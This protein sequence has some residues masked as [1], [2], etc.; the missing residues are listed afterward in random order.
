MIFSDGSQARPDA[1]RIGWLT[2]STSPGANGGRDA[3]SAS[4]IRTTNSAVG[5]QSSSL[6]RPVGGHRDHG[7]PGV[8]R[9]HRRPDG[10][11]LGDPGPGVAAQVGARDDQV[12]RPA[13]GAHRGETREDGVRRGAA[14]GADAGIVGVLEV[15]VA[16][17]VGARAAAVPVRGHLDDVVP[18]TVSA[19]CTAR[20]PPASYPSSSV[21]RMRSGGA[22][23]GR[24]VGGGRRGPGAGAATAVT[25]RPQAAAPCSRTRSGL[26]RRRPRRRSPRGPRAWV[27]SCHVSG[28]GELSTARGIGGRAGVG[29]ILGV[30]RADRTPPSSARRGRFA[31]RRRKIDRTIRPGTT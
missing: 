18:G 27:R 25:D 15:P 29:V 28:I 7:E 16:G 3:A 8:G 30:R 1:R 4:T 17:G 9:G 20:I 13:V 11:R 19:A 31:A 24:A 2:L 10:A 26:R 14:H 12:G 22:G 6:L 23:R 5:T 21:S